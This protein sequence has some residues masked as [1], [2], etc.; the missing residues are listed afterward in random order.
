MPPIPSL[1]SLPAALP[2]K[3]MKLSAIGHWFIAPHDPKHL[4]QVID[5]E[6]NRSKKLYDVN[7]L[8]TESTADT[9]F[10]LSFLA[11]PYRSTVR[12][13]PQLILPA[14]AKIQQMYLRTI[15][16]RRTMYIVLA[17]REYK[18]ANGRWPENLEQIKDKVPAE[19]MIDPFTGGSFIYKTKGDKFLLYSIGPNKIDEKGKPKPSCRDSSCRTDKSR[20][21]DILILPQ[22]YEQAKEFFDA[23]TPA[24]K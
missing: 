8:E 1:K 19:A 22:K 7:Q 4:S 23:N 13:M 5:E 6:F 12:M 2:Q 18:D 20:S 9:G 15:V 24:A 14:H 3:L 10:H 21:D 11:D 17:L 16:L